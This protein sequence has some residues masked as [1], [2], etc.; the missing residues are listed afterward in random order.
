MR[1]GTASNVAVVAVL[2]V[3]GAAW[4]NFAAEKREKPMLTESGHTTDDLSVVRARVANKEAVLLD[5]REK[6]E[7]DDGHLQAASLVPLSS[8]KDGMIPAEFVRLFPKD[9]PVYLHCRSGGRVLKCAEL[10]QGRGYDI[11]PLKAGYQKLVESGFEKAVGST[12]PRNP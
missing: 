3:L 5:V 4:P 10:L 8:L 11:R 9:R 12:S 6:D 1:I 7:W 2:A